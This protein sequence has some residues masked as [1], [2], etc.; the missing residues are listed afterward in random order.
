MISHPPR[1]TIPLERTI[2]PAQKKKGEHKNCP[3]LL[4]LKEEGRLMDKTVSL[5]TQNTRSLDRKV[6]STTPN[7]RS[8]LPKTRCRFYVEQLSLVYLRVEVSR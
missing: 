8:H 6:S 1:Q 7:Q 2:D 5:P 3:P 4:D